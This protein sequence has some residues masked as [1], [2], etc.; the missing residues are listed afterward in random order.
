MAMAATCS[1]PNGRVVP[2][3]G[4]PYYGDGPRAHL[5][6]FVALVSNSTNP[7]YWLITSTG[8]I[9]SVGQT[10]VSG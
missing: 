2:V 4:A 3:G 1:I 5:N 7:G 8:R 10:C 6:N 9:V